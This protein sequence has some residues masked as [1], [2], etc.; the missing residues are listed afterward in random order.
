MYSSLR[1]SVSAS[2]KKVARAGRERPRNYQVLT[3]SNKLPKGIKAAAS[4]KMNWK[5]NE[6]EVHLNCLWRERCS[7]ETA[8]EGICN[9]FIPLHIFLYVIDIQEFVGQ[10]RMADNPTSLLHNTVVLEPQEEVISTEQP[11]KGPSIFFSDS[12]NKSLPFFFSEAAPLHHRYPERTPNLQAA[13]LKSG[14]NGMNAALRGAF[15]R[16]NMKGT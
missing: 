10:N 5:M 1:L 2:N 4:F 12:F 9:A 13:G 6:P 8:W 11:K 14:N 16:S 3:F 15:P 7:K